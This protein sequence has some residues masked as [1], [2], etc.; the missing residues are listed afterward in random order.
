MRLPSLPY[1]G[2]Y[3]TDAQ[4]EFR[5]L[6]ANPGAED[7]EIAWM[8]NMT[9][10]YYPVMSVR[11]RRRRY[12][13][14]VNTPA[15][16]FADDAV[17][18]VDGSY[19]YVDGTPIDVLTRTPKQIA[20][21][22]RKIII[23]PDKKIYDMDAGTLT[24]MESSVS[25][26][27]VDFQNGT[28]F[29]ESAEANTL[30]KSGAAWGTYFK[31]GDAVTISG[32]VTH[33]ENNQTFIIRE[34]DG[35]YLRFY[36]YSFTLNPLWS[37]T[38]GEA[39]LAAG[40][41]YFTAGAD[42]LHFTLSEV[43]PTG[44]K[45]E[46]NGSILTRTV[47][48]I[49]TPVPTSSGIDGSRITMQESATRPYTELATMTFARTVPDMDY[50]CVNENRLWGCKGD[51]IYASKLGDPTNFSVFDGLS[52][53]S[54]QSQVGDRGDFTGCTSYL[55]YPIFFKEESV[56]KVYGDKP[57]NFQW[58]PS[59]R[60]GVA[61]GSHG[62]LA[63]ANETLYYLSPVGIVAYNGGIP[64]VISEPL[65]VDRRWKNAVAGSDGLRYYV[66]M[67]DAD[68]DFWNLYVYDTQR[69]MWHRE[70][71]THAVGFGYWDKALHTLSI[72]RN[73]WTL[74]GSSGWPQESAVSWN[75]EFADSTMGSPM[76][77]GVLR[78]LLR[79]EL[80]TGA[81]LTVSIR[82]DGGAYSAVRT[83]TAT[84]KQSYVLPLIVRRCDHWNLKLNGTGGCKVYSI[85]QTRYVGSEK[86]GAAYNGGV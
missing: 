2:R 64:K 29:G 32:A 18:W 11:D 73:L 68:T 5:G 43:L 66:S 12:A 15:A 52:T 6:N 49:M 86:Q 22:L 46:W 31:E 82:Y 39:D 7:G 74:D 16:L 57:A 53:D 48:G 4:T 76:K 9:G 71:A 77:K 44:G 67:Q 75:V 8:T 80:D 28:I 27:G 42:T 19:L 3:Y 69:G 24:S 25:L 35:D 72:D 62:S 78:V 51:T 83:V 33:P 40:T 63:V 45:L 13:E 54:W 59:A 56:F 10:K 60:F 50:I 55:G 17:V 14:T 84:Q 58:T 37:Y 20:R 1:N 47:R 61:A 70:D 65:G 34:I 30:Y 38:P 79:C 23:F 81:S 36:E 41:Y 21:M 85:A 26:Y